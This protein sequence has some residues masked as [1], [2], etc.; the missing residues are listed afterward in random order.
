MGVIGSKS[1]V[2]ESH[3]V[4]IVAQEKKDGRRA[5]TGMWGCQ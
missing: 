2:S 5:N 3:V 1:G 4:F